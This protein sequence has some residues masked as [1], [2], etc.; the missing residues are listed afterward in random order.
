MSLFRQISTDR[1]HG[2]FL[3][4]GFSLKYN[5]LLSDIFANTIAKQDTIHWLKNILDKLLLKLD[6]FI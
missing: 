2:A 5:G 3:T 1:G 4:P 6:V